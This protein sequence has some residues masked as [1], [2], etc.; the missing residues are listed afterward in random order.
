[1][2]QPKSVNVLDPGFNRIHA[3]RAVEVSLRFILEAFKQGAFV[4][5]HG[6]PRDTTALDDTSKV[7]SD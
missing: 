6:E 5:H 7:F 4:F 1:V 3:F 2:R